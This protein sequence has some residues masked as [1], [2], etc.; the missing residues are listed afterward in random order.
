M[1]NETDI[2][3]LWK[4]QEKRR[5]KA[6]KLKRNF[7]VQQ[8]DVTVVLAVV[9]GQMVEVRR[10]PAVKNNPEFYRNR[11]EQMKKNAT[12]HSRMF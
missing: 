6:E 8:T 12:L 4:A 11:Q 1:L 2:Q 9:G 5:M 3:K 10:Y 7:G